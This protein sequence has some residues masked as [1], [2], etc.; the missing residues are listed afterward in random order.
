M[1]TFTPPE[2]EKAAGFLQ[3][4]ADHLATLAPDARAAWFRKWIPAV[5]GFPV[6]ADL[7]AFAKSNVIITLESWRDMAREAA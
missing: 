5:K 4:C 2:S 3:R 6:D 7:T 1:F